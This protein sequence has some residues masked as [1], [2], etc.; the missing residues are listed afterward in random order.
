MYVEIFKLPSVFDVV[1]DEN[2][3]RK[4]VDHCCNGALWVKVIVLFHSVD[5]Y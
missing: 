5:L 3:C 4:S 1:R 2:S